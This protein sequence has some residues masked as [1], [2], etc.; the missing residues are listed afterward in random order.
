M[1]ELEIGMSIINFLLANRLRDT[2]QE[3]IHKTTNM[4]E[5]NPRINLQKMPL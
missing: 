1:D 3:Q 5:T 2:E 4:Y